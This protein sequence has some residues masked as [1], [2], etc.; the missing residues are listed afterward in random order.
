M[1]LFLKSK[2]IKFNFIKSQRIYNK[3]R[4]SKVRLF[5]RAIFFLSLTVGII[6]N[7]LSLDMSMWNLDWFTGILFVESVIEYLFIFVMFL[8][9]KIISKKLRYLYL[10]LEEL[11]FNFETFIFSYNTDV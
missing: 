3:R 5:S 10:F 6:I 8:I 9:Y 11:W 1:L 2:K 4:Y 7:L